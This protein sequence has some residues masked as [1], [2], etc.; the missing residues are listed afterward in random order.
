MVQDGV[1]D[2]GFDEVKLPQDGLLQDGLA[3]QISKV[4]ALTDPIRR[5]LYHFVAHQPGSVSRDQAAEGIDVPRH[6]AKFHLDK[7]VDEGLLITE[8]RR[9][10]GR[11]GPG[12]GRP[13]K[14]YRRVRSEISVSLPRRRYDFASQVLADAVE[15]ALVGTPI[16]QALTGAVRDGA[17]VVTEGWPRAGGTELE[18]IEALLSRLGYEPRVDADA[19]KVRNCPYQ[20]ISA[21]HP[22]L[23]CPMNREFVE[24]AAHELGCT[25]LA[26][27]SVGPG[28]GCCVRVIATGEERARG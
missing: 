13:A 10:T 20:Q 4:G 18:R 24:A 7:L 25:G 22:A 6:T 11:S 23:V 26:V 28:T 19:I 1:A 27:E 3:Q 8:F 15:R 2:G 17:R 16:Q 14:L 12:A 5:A 21:E 9:L